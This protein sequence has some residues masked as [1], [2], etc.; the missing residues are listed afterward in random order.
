MVFTAGPKD[1][2]L[3]L[4]VHVTCQNSEKAS[5]LLGE[6]E[7]T[8]DTLRSWLA[9]EHKRPNAGDLS[10]ILTAGSFRQDDRN[11]FGTWP[12]QR[13]FLQNIGGGSNQ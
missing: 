2:H 11:V 4:A 3:E 13:S 8:T 12:V 5:A 7:S 9:R 1:D 6:L 10:G